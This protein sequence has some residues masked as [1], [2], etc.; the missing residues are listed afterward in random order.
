[1]IHDNLG[2]TALEVRR[3]PTLAGRAYAASLLRLEGSGRIGLVD[4]TNPGSALAESN[5]G[6]MPL[7]QVAVATGSSLHLLV[8]GI[9]GAA[10]AALV[11]EIAEIDSPTDEIREIPLQVPVSGQVGARGESRY[12]VPGVASGEYTIYLVGLS[13]DADLRVFADDTYSLELDCSL[14]RPGDVDRQPEACRLS[15][16]DAIHF[17]V[18]SGELNR[19]GATYTLVVQ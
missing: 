18:R 19:V 5:T 16:A 17:S 11:S 10:Y 6:A 7:E 12:S 1:M 9:P 14:R 8:E 15:A 3:I 4:S 2:T 13:D